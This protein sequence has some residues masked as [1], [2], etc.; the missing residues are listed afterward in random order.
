M[1]GWQYIVHLFGFI[2]HRENNQPPLGLP[3]HIR[4]PMYALSVTLIYTVPIFSQ[5]IGII[6][7][8]HMGVI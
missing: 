2:F 4:S 5:Y 3:T 8:H 7:C 1:S 6:T